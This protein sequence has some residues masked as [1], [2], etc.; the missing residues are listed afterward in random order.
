MEVVFSFCTNT[1]CK[2]CLILIQEIHLFTFYTS[3]LEK[4]IL[5]KYAQDY[6]ML[7]KDLAKSLSL[8]GQKKELHYVL[9]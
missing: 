2:S 6:K 7:D 5:H 9:N 8:N 4:L 1:Y 3:A